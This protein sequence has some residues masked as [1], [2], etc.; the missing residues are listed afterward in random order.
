MNPIEKSILQ[1]FC[2]Q[3]HFFQVYSTFEFTTIHFKLMMQFHQKG[4]SQ[5]NQM[6]WYSTW[7]WAMI[8]QKSS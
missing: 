1:K 4:K 5:N 2:N 8:V 6:E 7:A 3:K